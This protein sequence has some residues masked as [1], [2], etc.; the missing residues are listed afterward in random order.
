MCRSV[1]DKTTEA[2]R[3]C[4]NRDINAPHGLYPARPAAECT[5]A[6]AVK[7]YELLGCVQRWRRG[8]GV[9]RHLTGVTPLK[10]SRRVFIHEIVFRNSYPTARHHAIARLFPSGVSPSRWY[11]RR[12]R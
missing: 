10:S 11:A 7:C 12:I 2:Q 4:L 3:K 9:R 5:S 8:A 6:S 1:S